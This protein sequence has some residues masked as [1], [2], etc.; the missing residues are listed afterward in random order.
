MTPSRKPAILR[1]FAAASL[2]T[3]A[4][5]AGHVTGGG[6]MPGVLGILVP[7][8]FSFMVCVLLAGR[9]LS[10]IR[11]SISVAISQ[12]LF[13]VLFVLGTIEPSGH[14]GGHVHGAPV[15]LPASTGMAEAVVADGTM[16]AGHLLAA[17]V[18]VVIAHRGERM[19]LGLREIAVQIVVWVRRR[20]EA[21]LVLLEVLNLRGLR[22]VW[23]RSRP[24]ESRV[25]ATLRG[26]A[27]PAV[28]AI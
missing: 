19:L 22:E 25:L 15:V 8:I 17:V 21:V 27:P 18:T 20:V 28:R 2:A 9:K 12:I 3:F 5:L 23:D 4:A 26:R 14:T 7:W 24:L 13:H 10:V 6:Q 16:W 11:L 1:G